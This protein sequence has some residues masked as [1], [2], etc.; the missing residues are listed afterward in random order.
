MASRYSSPHHGAGRALTVR[1]GRVTVVDTGP[2]TSWIR[3]PASMS[4]RS[5]TPNRVAEEIV[6]T[7]SP[8]PPPARRIS[9][10]DVNST[11]VATKPLRPE[12]PSKRD[13]TLTGVSAT[14]PSDVR[15]ADPLTATDEPFGRS[16]SDRTVTLEA[17]SPKPWLGMLRPTRTGTLVNRPTPS[18]LV[19]PAVVPSFASFSI[20][21]L[22]TDRSVQSQSSF[23]S[24]APRGCAGSQ[25]ARS[26]RVLRVRS[27]IARRSGSRRRCSLDAGRNSAALARTP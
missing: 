27:T 13:A 25:A 3:F 8:V 12:R 1:N 15:P 9:G 4:T 19:A 11:L 18:R 23:A 21:L 17:P 2:I 7:F 16:F 5:P 24:S 22:V 10:C 26:N 6:I 14:P 20:G